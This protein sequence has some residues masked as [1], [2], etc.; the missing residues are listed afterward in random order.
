L[1]K[2]GEEKMFVILDK[3]KRWVQMQIEDY[4]GKVKVKFFDLHNKRGRDQFAETFAPKTCTI[5]KD[6]EKK[7]NKSHQKILE[8]FGFKQLKK[9]TQWGQAPL[10]YLIEKKFQ[11]YNRKSSW[12]KNYRG[13]KLRQLE[14]SRIRM[15]I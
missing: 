7:V 1:E 14:T 5:I 3:G 8:D 11:L 2:I 6:E 10:N 9:K 4:C 13:Q 12:Q 15:D